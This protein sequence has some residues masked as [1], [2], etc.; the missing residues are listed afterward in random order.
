[1]MRACNRMSGMDQG[2]SLTASYE[3]RQK[4]SWD[5]RF[6]RGWKSQTVLACLSLHEMAGSLIGWISLF[7]VVAQ[8]SAQGE[9]G[10]F[11]V[12]DCSQPCGGAYLCFPCK[13]GTFKARCFLSSTIF[14]NMQCCGSYSNRVTTCDA[15]SNAHCCDSL[16]LSNSTIA[17]I[18][19]GCVILVIGLA[20][21][22]WWAVRRYRRTHEGYEDLDGPTPT[23]YAEQYAAHQKRARPY[24]AQPPNV[25]NA[26]S[27]Y[28]SYQSY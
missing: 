2:V 1:M 11:P 9:V 15:S 5:G 22:A 16:H 17:G 20:F 21:F 10:S 25:D 23:A 4:H 27:P 26:P 24:A 14:P 28:G 19:I 7:L 18:A 8:V 13:Y 6:R 12:A 3:T